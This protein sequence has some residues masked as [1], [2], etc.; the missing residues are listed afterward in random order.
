[1]AD[2]RGRDLKAGDRAHFVAGE[3]RITVV[4]LRRTAPDRYLVQLDQGGA[5]DLPARPGLP[6]TAATF[7]DEANLL[8]G[9]A[10]ESRRHHEPVE[11]RGESLEL[12]PGDEG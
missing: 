9:Y 6:S 7:Y 8:L 5:L 2:R 11:V 10:R 4:V 12:I 1:V 3:E